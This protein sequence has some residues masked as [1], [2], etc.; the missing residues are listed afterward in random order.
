MVPEEIHHCL[1]R[2]HPDD[3]RNCL[4]TGKA[5]TP[6][7][8]PEDK[9]QDCDR[10]QDDRRLVT[11]WNDCFRSWTSSANDSTIIRFLDLTRG[12]CLCGWCSPSGGPPAQRVRDE[13]LPTGAV[14]TESPG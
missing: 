2:W 11:A 9:A 4:I 1:D 14:V 5:A 10:C 12:E 7:A 13:R 8:D 3:P 6:H